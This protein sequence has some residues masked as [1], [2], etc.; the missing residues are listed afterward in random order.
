[1]GKTQRAYIQIDTIN[2]ADPISE[3]VDTLNCTEDVKDKN[4]NLLMKLLV[5]KHITMRYDNRKNIIKLYGVTVDNE[6]KVRYDSGK[7]VCE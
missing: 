3:F 2:T 6:G 7:K 4:K 1:M 5:T